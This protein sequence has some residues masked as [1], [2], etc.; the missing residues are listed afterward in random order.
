MSPSAT[1]LSNHSR[2]VECSR[3]E[4]SRVQQQDRQAHEQL[5]EAS[6]QCLLNIARNTTHDTTR[7]DTTRHDTTRHDMTRHDTKTTRPFH[8][9]SRHHTTT[10]TSHA[11]CCAPCHCK[12]HGHATNAA[13]PALAL[14]AEQPGPHPRQRTPCTQR[15]AVVDGDE[16]AWSAT[17]RLT[18]AAGSPSPS[19]EDHCLKCSGTCSNRDAGRSRRVH[20]AAVKQV[21]HGTSPPAARSLRLPSNVAGIQSRQTSAACLG[22]R[23]DAHNTTAAG[24][25]VRH[26]AH[27][28]AHHCWTQMFTRVWPQTDHVAEEQGCGRDRGGLHAAKPQVPSTRCDFRP[29]Q[30]LLTRHRRRRRSFGLRRCGWATSIPTALR[31]V[32][33]APLPLRAPCRRRVGAAVA[34]SPFSHLPCVRGSA[35]APVPH[36]LPSGP[37]SLHSSVSRPGARARSRV[38]LARRRLF[39]AS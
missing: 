6:R 4:Q 13:S 7:H 17:H 14:C 10:K 12:T 32:A 20:D 29:W 30:S 34:A 8:D 18:T 9:D 15:G 39:G 26:T 22:L 21:R 11:T 27:A 36:V 19:T 31:C 23:H 5:Q 38:H 33:G 37:R 35:D 3:K 28:R 2:R 25:S 24:R 1:Q 16:R